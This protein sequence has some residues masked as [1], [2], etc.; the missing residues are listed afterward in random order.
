MR[1]VRACCSDPTAAS[2]PDHQPD[3]TGS[4]VDVAGGGAGSVVTGGASVVVG[5][6]AMVVVVDV[7]VV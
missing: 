3:G 4:V 5:L 6:G 1:F 7:V 2:P